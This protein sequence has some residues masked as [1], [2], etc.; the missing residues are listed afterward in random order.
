MGTERDH[1]ETRL[2]EVQSISYNK[3]SSH[4]A[5]LLSQ[6][7]LSV[8]VILSSLGIMAATSAVFSKY[9][10]DTLSAQLTQY[11]LAGLFLFIIPEV[12]LGIVIYRRKL[13]KKFTQEAEAM[14][15]EKES[16]FFKKIESDFQAMVKTSREIIR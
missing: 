12:I 3:R 1:P 9:L 14:L 5:E 8:I 15:R 16:L 11:I 7:A 6:L 13:R 10:R 4:L 2:D